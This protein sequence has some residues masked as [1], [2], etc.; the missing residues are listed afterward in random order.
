M[1]APHLIVMVLAKVHSILEQRQEGEVVLQR[2]GEGH[3]HPWLARV[4]VDSAEMEAVCQALDEM[5]FSQPDPLVRSHAVV[6]EV[7]LAVN[8]MG[9]GWVLLVAGA[10]L[11]FTNVLWVQKATVRGVEAGGASN[12][13]SAEVV[14]AVLVLDLLL[15]AHHHVQQVAEEEVGGRQ[16]I[17]P[18]LGDGKLLVA[19][20]T[21]QLQGLTGTALAL[22]ALPAEGVQAGQDMEPLGG[23]VGGGGGVRGGGRGGG[24]G[25]DGSGGSAQLLAERTRLQVRVWK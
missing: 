24:A 12:Q 18:G 11:R 25:G 7:L 6:T 17:H 15:G 5:V 2:L 23:V 19:S 14:V 9:R 13:A 4:A 10:A 21:P 1:C 16:G 3:G 8:A 20:G 22:Q